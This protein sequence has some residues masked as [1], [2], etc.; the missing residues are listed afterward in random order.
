MRS[1]NICTLLLVW[2]LVASPDPSISSGNLN[3]HIESLFESCDN[4]DIPGGFAAAVIHNGE[5]IFKKGYGSANNEHN[6]PFTTRTVTDFA[7]VAKQFTGF[8]IATLADQGRLNLDDD[9]RLYIPDVPDFGD[10]ITIRHLLHH[11]SGIRDWVGLVKIAGRYDEDVI[12]EE[13]IMKLVKHQREL[14]FRPGERY[15]YSNTGYFLLARIVTVVTGQPFP[16]WMRDNVFAPLGMDNTRF[17]SDFREILPGR[18]DSYVRDDFGR[19]AN[20]TSNLESCGSSSLFSTID[21]MIKWVVNLETRSLGGDG[22]W[23]AMLRPGVLNNGEETSY[24]YGLSLGEK[25]GYTSFG[26]GGSWGGYLCTVTR[27]P[28]LGL[29]YVLVFNRDPGGA[30]VEDG[31]FELFVPG[32]QVTEPPEPARS[33]VSV[34][35]GQL[36]RYK[37][38][39]VMFGGVARIESGDHQ[40]FIR[41]PWGARAEFHPESQTTFFD[42]DVDAQIEFVGNQ[43]G[44]FNRVAFVYQGNGYGPF[45]RANY[46]VSTYVD[47][48]DFCGDY[49]CP[50]LRTSYTVRIENNRLVLWHLHNEDVLL[51]QK[52]PDTYI[53]D[54]W[55]CRKLTLQRDDGGRITGFTL[56]ADNNNIQ[57]VR[58]IRQ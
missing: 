20:T 57:G 27:Y 4:P 48:A 39:F 44:E 17:V 10:T 13:F 22:L 50:E 9:I 21:D 2:C 24:G 51:L 37:G 8:A 26:H 16:E 15:Q 56:D 46:D 34:A 33:P 41:Y 28:D 18:A 45:D 3:S 42:K 6:I 43:E 19:Y 35:P 7:S 31:L 40:L 47:P 30:Y 11:T 52:D 54:A 12:T 55:W 36:A 29:S 49:Y 1:S 23:E 32:E 38:R 14:N 58:F 25:R 53:G 5:V